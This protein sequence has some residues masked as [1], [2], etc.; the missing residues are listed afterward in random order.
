MKPFD[1]ALGRMKLLALLSAL[2]LLS[3]P[4]AQA[5]EDGSGDSKGSAI[6]VC[7]P[8]GQRAYLARLACPGGQPPSYK[9]IGSVGPRSPFPAEASESDKMALIQRVGLKRG[10]PDYHIVD[11][12]DITCGTVTRRIY[13]DMYHCDRSDPMSA[14]VGSTH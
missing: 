2:I 11:E 14:P 10:E 9:R 7:M 3:I 6:E 1:S 13:M 4:F 8:A 12:Y 5:A